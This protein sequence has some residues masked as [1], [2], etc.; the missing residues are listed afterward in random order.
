MPPF[1]YEA[2]VR[3]EMA[4]ARGAF[5]EAVGQL[6]LATAA[7]EEDPY[8]L[9]RLAYA[10]ARA[11]NPQEAE[12]TLAHALKL[13][14]CSEAV[15]LTRAELAE[16]AGNLGKA[17][18][19]YAQASQCAPLSA[20]GPIGRARALDRAG[21]PG[22]TIEVLGAFAGRE[23]PDRA[24]VALE[25]FL[26]GSDPAVLAHALE[27]WVAYEA[28]DSATLEHAA[29]W[30]LQRDLPA[31]AQRVRE[32]HK[33]PFPKH[34]DAR[35][36]RAL[37][38]RAQLRSLLSQ[39]TAEELGGTRSTAELA[40][41]AG[42]YERAELE[43]TSALA[44]APGDALHALRAQ[45]RFALGM[46]EQGLEDVRA[47]GDGNVRRE[48]LLGLLARSGSPALSQELREIAKGVPAEAGGNAREQDQ[49]ADGAAPS[50]RAQ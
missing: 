7:P 15:W 14:A 32:H 45:A 9:S 29:S 18:S 41:F 31:L 17:D 10:Q 1:A 5:E 44:T 6:E 47:I 4:I 46:R 39:S 16:L 25:A 11:G 43:A 19:A 12:Q 3:G 35:I 49:E 20:R 13:D 2:Y 42:D 48:A 8:L 37:G 50:S 34:L 28:P 30:A 21:K 22:A 24:R 36:A 23:E 33:G 26:H 40:L 38:A 27:T